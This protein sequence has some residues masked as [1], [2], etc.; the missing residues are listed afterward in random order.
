[1]AEDLISSILN[2]DA[3][4]AELSALDKKLQ[5]FAD[6]LTKF[7][8]FTLFA[9]ASNLKQVKDAGNQLSSVMDQLKAKNL[10]LNNTLKQLSIIQKQ[11]AIDSKAAADAKKAAAQATTDQTSSSQKLT[12]QQKIE[13]AQ[14]QSAVGSYNQ[15]NATL[16]LLQNQY[17]S[18]SESDRNSPPGQSI[19]ANIVTTKNSLKDL[20]SSLG[21]H[22]RKVG[23]YTDAIAES[24]T[25]IA[26]RVLEYVAAYAGIDAIK[27][28][29]TESLTLALDAEKANI[30]FAG[31]LDNLGRSDAFD[32]LSKTADNLVGKFAYLNKTD[33][34]NVF[35]QLVTFGKLSENQIN[36]LTPV[37]IN[38]AAKSGLSLKEATTDIETAIEGNSKGLRQYGINI[39]DAKTEVDRFGVIMDQLAPK[40]NGAAE[41]FGETTQGK[42]EATKERFH[43]L[44]KEIG[45]NLLPTINNMLTG[46]NNFLSDYN[47]GGLDKVAD[48]LK[49][50]FSALLDA[51]DYDDLINRLNGIQKHVDDLNASANATPAEKKGILSPSF[52]ANPLQTP[53]QD[54][55]LG[56]SSPDAAFDG[57]PGL[58][59]V[60]DAAYAASLK[61]AQEYHKQALDAIKK[62]DEEQLQALRDK[63]KSEAD[64]QTKSFSFRLAAESAYGVAGNDLIQK[65]KQDALVDLNSEIANDKKNAKSKEELRQIEFLAETKQN[66]II[67]TAAKQ[68]SDFEISVAKDRT[69]IIQQEYAK[70]ADTIKQN[71]NEISQSV[72][73]ANDTD[74]D[75]AQITE[76]NKLLQ[77]DKDYHDGKIGN[78][79]EYNEK[80]KKLEESA[81]IDEIQTDINNNNRKLNIDLK[82]RQIEIDQLGLLNELEYKAGLITEEQYKKTDNELLQDDKDLARQRKDIETQNSDDI[83]K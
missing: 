35:Q 48:R 57:G 79:I 18:L 81:A 32:R 47:C 9:D 16:K 4:D 33:V 13:Q 67:K 45:D 27:K 22:Q 29:F 10:D 3:I 64:D 37:I 21:D 8:K 42:I 34:I 59:N 15:L 61:R 56:Q 44:E 23:S 69:K 50:G 60:D 20:D 43:D 7:P 74:K 41:A 73:D 83:V 65:T 77:L 24:F 68:T 5:A 25:H 11:N 66:E 71:Y 54:Y 1:M 26:E 40:V 14:I 78:L 62:A 28:F 82:A 49:L 52:L 31:T 51:K 30:I 72:T 39:K 36:E 17:K 19:A 76:N 6:A 2:T 58:S 70:V 55:G 75:N 38:F 12:Q 53:Q 46:V 80:R 63:Y